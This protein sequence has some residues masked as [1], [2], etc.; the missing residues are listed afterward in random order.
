[1][2]IHQNF[3]VICFIHIGCKGECCGPREACFCR[4]RTFS[5]GPTIR[6]PWDMVCLFS[7]VVVNF[8]ILKFLGHFFQ[9]TCTSLQKPA[10][11][12]ALNGSCRLSKHLSK[13]CWQLPASLTV[14]RKHWAN[15]VPRIAF[16]YKCGKQQGEVTGKI[17]KIN[18]R[19][20][21]FTLSKS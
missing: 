7:V 14:P 10:V 11:W 17:E 13:K 6:R 18:F 12:Q 21:N 20:S 3:E 19:C 16:L 2:H 4:I 5:L 8:F 15:G 1:M 9:V